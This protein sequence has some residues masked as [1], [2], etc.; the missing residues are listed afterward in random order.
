ML[1]PLMAVNWAASVEVPMPVCSVKSCEEGGDWRLKR[2][3]MV[4]MC[5]GVIGKD[6]RR[7]WRSKEKLGPR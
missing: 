7:P 3:A 5:Y 4:N 2:N 1:L 6:F